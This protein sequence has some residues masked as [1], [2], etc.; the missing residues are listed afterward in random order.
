MFEDRKSVREAT[1]EVFLA[2]DDDQSKSER[3]K[4]ASDDPCEEK[5]K[6]GK[7]GRET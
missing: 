7:E 4:K 5:R 1:D 2:S 6:E 3:S